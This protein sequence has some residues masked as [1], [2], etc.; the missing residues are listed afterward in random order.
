MLVA[1]IEFKCRGRTVRACCGRTTNSSSSC[2]KP[3]QSSSPCD[4][5]WT[6]SAA[7][8]PTF[9][10]PP[11]LP[12][13]CILKSTSSQVPPTPTATPPQPPPR[14]AVQ[15][16]SRT[17][18]TSATAQLPGSPSPRRS[19]SVLQSPRRLRGGL[20]AQ[21]HPESAEEE[22]GEKE[23]RGRGEQSVGR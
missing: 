14:C 19:S 23:A 18:A 15:P 13:R 6:P 7:N 20:P 21:V 3:T 1:A 8:S 17:P 12:V 4:R 10:R 9:I 5:K 2:A 22:Y 11:P 16:P